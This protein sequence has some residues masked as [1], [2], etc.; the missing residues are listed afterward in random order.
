[1]QWEIREFDTFDRDSAPVQSE[2]GTGRSAGFAAL[3]RLHLQDAF[4]PNG[5]DTFTAVELRFT[6]SMERYSLPCGPN[7]SSAAAR[8]RA[9][10]AGP[11]QLDWLATEYQRVYQ[12]AQPAFAGE[13][14]YR[15]GPPQTLISPCGRSVVEW[16]TSSNQVVN[17]ALRD[18]A[19][20]RNTGTLIERSDASLR[21]LRFLGPAR[22]LLYSAESGDYYDQSLQSSVSKK[23]ANPDDAPDEYGPIVLNGIRTP[24]S[25]IICLICPFIGVA[26]VGAV[27]L[28]KAGAISAAISVSFL[29]A[30]L[31]AFA[32]WLETDRR[33]Q[34]IDPLRGV[35]VH[36]TRS[37]FHHS[38]SR[39]LVEEFNALETR[40]HSYIGV[41]IV[42]AVLTGKRD[43]VL[44]D[45]S[46]SALVA[47]RLNFP[48]N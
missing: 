16:W 23:L 35:I 6:A 14:I 12:P 13:E 38:V 15:I 48:L 18:R 26:A 27:F 22:V 46:Q 41:V 29:A 11:E 4:Q 2:A 7:W 1:V 36:D 47:S 44:L 31:T 8:L 32:A 19:T 9:W 25:L 21:P 24:R 5:A 45:N 28:G 10:A 43:L 17:L 20:G 3:W 42:Q 39:Y 40:R 33:R 30:A 34:T 37:C